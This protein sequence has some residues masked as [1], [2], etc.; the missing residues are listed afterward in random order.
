MNTHNAATA[1]SNLSH[2]CIMR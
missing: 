2:G 1:Y